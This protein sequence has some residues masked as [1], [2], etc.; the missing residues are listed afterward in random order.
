MRPRKTNA[1]NSSQPFHHKWESGHRLRKTALHYVTETPV[2]KN[3][4]SE[5]ILHI[6]FLR[7][8]NSYWVTGM[9]LTNTSWS[10]CCLNTWVWLQAVAISSSSSHIKFTTW[11]RTL[12]GN[13]AFY[14]FSLFLFYV[15]SYM[16]DKRGIASNPRRKISVISR[17][18][19]LLIIAQSRGSKFNWLMLLGLDIDATSLRRKWEWGNAIISNCFKSSWLDGSWHFIKGVSPVHGM[20]RQRQTLKVM[21]EFPWGRALYNTCFTSK[22]GVLSGQQL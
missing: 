10:T 9:P 21:E 22:F 20:A 13:L 17:E 11:K 8:Q 3:K 12:E 4:S 15:F 19:V 16:Q 7:C 1:V 2:L 5:G 14:F 6:V 18:C